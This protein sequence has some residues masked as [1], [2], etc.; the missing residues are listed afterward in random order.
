MSDIQHLLDEGKKPTEISKI[1]DIPIQTVQRNIKYVKDLAV[2][3]LTP[4]V[5]AEKRKEIYTE[6]LDV[7]MK[8][9]EAFDKYIDDKPSTA[10]GFLSSWM[11]ALD[12]RASLFGLNNN[13]PEVQTQVN[14]LNV[15][16]AQ[17]QQIVTP[18]DA[19]RIAKALIKKHEQNLL[20]S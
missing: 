2:T 7:T 9:R 3:D 12:K 10:K 1:M 5:I 13:G 19:N 6:L 16:P 11:T 18:S 4:E 17:P 15:V 14:N 20:N 8:A